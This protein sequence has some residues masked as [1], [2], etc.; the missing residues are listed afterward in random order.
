MNPQNPEL[1]KSQPTENLTMR[2]IE[3]LAR[4]LPDP[5]SVIIFETF[6]GSGCWTAEIFFKGKEVRHYGLE[7]GRGW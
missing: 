3:K 6:E 5:Y 7:T 4:A 2:E 1:Q